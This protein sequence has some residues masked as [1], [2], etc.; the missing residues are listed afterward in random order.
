MEATK[1]SLPY[2]PKVAAAL[3]WLSIIILYLLESSLPSQITENE[4]Y[5]L[6]IKIALNLTVAA[7][8]Y[9][10]AKDKEWDEERARL[11]AAIAVPLTEII[12]PIYLVK[13]RGWIGA[14]KSVLRFC[15][16]SAVVLIVLTI[17][18][19]LRNQ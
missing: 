14:G 9:L 19:M 13:S 4:F 12:V 5:V 1:E 16:Y 11:Y 8:I 18:H 6:G 3:F 2:K 10:D 15:L 7:W 17:M